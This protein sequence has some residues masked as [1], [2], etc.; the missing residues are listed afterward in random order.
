M[1][2]TFTQ[3]SSDIKSFAFYLLITPALLI[4]VISNFTGSELKQLLSALDRVLERH[5]H[6]R[7]QDKLDQV[8][9]LHLKQFQV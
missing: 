3:K 5:R 9:E 8:I 7:L 1:S 6:E 2:L 4:V